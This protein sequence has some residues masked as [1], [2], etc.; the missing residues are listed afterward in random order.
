MVIEE[1]ET[2][3]IGPENDAEPI[4]GDMIMHVHDDSSLGIFIGS[5]GSRSIVVWTQEPNL[6]ARAYQATQSD[7]P[8]SSLYR[9][10]LTM[11]GK[12]VPALGGT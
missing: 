3:F 12:L 11:V 7:D 1:I 4:P 10:A 8:V 6:I 2:R 9:E 5:N